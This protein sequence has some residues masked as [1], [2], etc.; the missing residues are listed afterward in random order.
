MTFDGTYYC[1]IYNYLLFY[2]YSKFSRDFKKNDNHKC[3]CNVLSQLLVELII[4]ITLKILK[5][6][7]VKLILLFVRIK[8]NIFFSL[9]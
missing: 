6:L 5:A 9:F 7:K 2:C 4:I 1:A 3:E 8:K